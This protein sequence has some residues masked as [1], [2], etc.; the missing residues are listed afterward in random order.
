MKIPTLSTGDKLKI[1]LADDSSLCLDRTREI[2]DKHGF[3]G[4]VLTCMCGQDVL[5]IVEEHS[6]D[7]ILLDLFLPDIYGIDV[8][9]KI[10]E[11]ES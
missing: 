5:D 7:I 2:L 6:P 11:V 4:K 8:L 10:R 1:L 3:E 9:R